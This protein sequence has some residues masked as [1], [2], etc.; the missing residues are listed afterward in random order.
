MCTN[1]SDRQA[2]NSWD[3]KK[4]AASVTLGVMYHESGLIMMISPHAELKIM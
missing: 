2:G 4:K 3:V 1:N